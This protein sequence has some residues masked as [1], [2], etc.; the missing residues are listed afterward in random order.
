VVWSLSSGTLVFSAPDAIVLAGYRKWDG[1][2][3]WGETT[4]VAFCDSTMLGAG[5]SDGVA[6]C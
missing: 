3:L 2:S 4:D 6:V 5:F 1:Y